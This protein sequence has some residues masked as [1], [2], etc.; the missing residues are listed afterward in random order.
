MYISLKKCQNVKNNLLIYSC[1]FFIN[2]CKYYAGNHYKCKMNHLN[3]MHTIIH[4]LFIQFWI[5][6][7]GISKNILYNSFYVLSISKKNHY[8]KFQNL[9]KVQIF[10]N[11]E[12]RNCNFKYLIA[13]YFNFNY[14]I[15]K[16][17]HFLQ[18]LVEIS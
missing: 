10:W 4:Y 8:F 11:Y 17:V 18:K 2:V 3:S 1:F 13:F 9:F 6:Y 12:I 14:K 7:C 5:H 16:I 15:L